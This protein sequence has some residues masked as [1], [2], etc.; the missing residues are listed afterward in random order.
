MSESLEVLF[1]RAAGAR[2]FKGLGPRQKFY[3]Q[4][5]T[6]VRLQWNV[7]RKKKKRLFFR[8]WRYFSHIASILCLNYF[9]FF[10]FF[11]LL[12]MHQHLTRCDPLPPPPPPPIHS[13]ITIWQYFLCNPNLN[14]THHAHRSCYNSSSPVKGMRWWPSEW[15]WAHFTYTFHS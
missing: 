5:C 6:S 7:K 9:S 1:I 11:C 14:L 12:R 13:R 3:L 2:L 4:I 10:F 8:I 15:V